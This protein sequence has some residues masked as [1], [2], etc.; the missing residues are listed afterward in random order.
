[1]RPIQKDIDTYNPNS[2]VAIVLRRSNS[3]FMYPNDLNLGMYLV[4]Q[5]MKT[6]FLKL[7]RNL[8]TFSTILRQYVTL[9][10]YKI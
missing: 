4:E 7:H 2:I 9:L 1:M 5:R 10:F 8:F 6:D 3:K